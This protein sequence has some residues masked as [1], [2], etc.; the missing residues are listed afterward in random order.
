MAH[1]NET[2][3]KGILRAIARR[4]MLERGLLPDFQAPELAELNSLRLPAQKSAPEARDLRGLPWCSIDNTESRDLD[5]LTYAEP[6]VGGPFKVLVAVSDVDALVRKQSALDNH[7]G[8]NTCSVYTAAEIFPMLP[9]KLSTDLT[10]LVFSADRLAIV[11][12]MSVAP[13]GAV[14]NHDVY[15]AWVRNKAK[16]AYSKVAKW[17]DGELPILAEIEAIK[18]LEATL[19]LQ[20][21]VAQKMK[22][23]RHERGALEFETIH[24]SPVFEA[25]IL[26]D[27][28]IDKSDRAKDIIADFMIAANAVVATYLSARNFPSLRR[29]V[30]VPKRWDRIVAIAS[31]RGYKLPDEP[32]SLA[33]NKFLTAERKAD[34]DRF[35]DLSLSVVKLL[36]SGEYTVETP[37]GTNPG[38]FGLAMKDYTHSTAP[39]RR[40]SDLVT[41]RQVKAALFRLP[42]PYSGQELE[43]LAKHCTE[44]EDTVNKVERQV[45]KSAAALLLRH[46][47]GETFEGIVTG[48]AE[49]GTW[50]RLLHLPVEGRVVSGEAGLDVGVKLR[51]RLL[52]TDV[53]A[54]HIDFARV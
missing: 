54:G 21:S 39:N 4:V 47:I 5:Q 3:H 49:K 33:L 26:K 9:E 17:L 19:R 31:E 40:F 46:R 32:D 1:H 28:V 53:E 13:D 20:D 45:D 23:L 6:Q 11:V 50:V 48:S 22:E 29:V 51:V 52:S 18:G 14:T 43:I 12:E 34:P 15:T 24:A 27:L 44:A 35:P 8:H 7:A 2:G 42:P 36:G 38:H 37:Q 30:R 25:E 41:Q 16:L 10:S